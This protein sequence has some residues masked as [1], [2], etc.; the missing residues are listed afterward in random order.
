MR[1]AKHAFTLH[2]QLDRAIGDAHD[3]A[4]DRGAAT[5]GTK[6]EGTFRTSTATVSLAYT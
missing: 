4:T 2:C 1:S 6:W 5:Q 3:P